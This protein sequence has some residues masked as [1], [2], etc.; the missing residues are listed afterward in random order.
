MNDNKEH[1]KYA[2]FYVLLNKLPYDGDRKDLKKEIVLQYTQNRTDSL[3]K[4]TEQEYNTCIRDL[5]RISQEGP[6]VTTQRERL[7]RNRS[8]CLKLMQMI[9][10][11]TAD[12]ARINNFCQHPRIA[13]K[14]F[15]QITVE[16]LRLLAVKLRSIKAKG[17]L[18]KHPEDARENGPIYIEYMTTDAAEA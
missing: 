9:G 2:W 6:T 5:T 1:S 11:N 13:G 7:R 18:A 8:V 17:G 16:E 15:A 4:M 14:P 3:K 12:W 10:I